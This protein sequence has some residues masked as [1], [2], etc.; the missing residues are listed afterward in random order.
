[1]S[2]SMTKIGVKIR[3][4]SCGANAL[5]GMPECTRRATSWQTTV[6]ERVALHGPDENSLN[7]HAFVGADSCNPCAGNDLQ[8]S[9]ARAANLLSHKPFAARSWR[10]SGLHKGREKEGELGENLTRVATLVRWCKFN[11]VGAVGILVQFGVLFLL[12]SVLHFNYLAATAL[13]VEVAVVHNFFWHER[14]TWADRPQTSR[15]GN[16]SGAKAKSFPSSLFAVLTRGATQK[17]AS[18]TCT[19]EARAKPKS[20]AAGKSARSRQTNMDTLIQK[21]A[22]REL[23]SSRVARFVRFNLT[24]GLVSIGGNLGMMRVMVGRVHMNYLVANGIA[25]V[26]CSLVNFVVSDGWVFGE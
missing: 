21:C 11:L 4:T 8:A 26:V 10:G 2:A 20:K 22:A 14:Y 7:A 23:R 13:A 16:P 12:K 18:P 24:T 6:G 3:A 9:A 25:I 5:R 19:T 1:M 17:R 15:D